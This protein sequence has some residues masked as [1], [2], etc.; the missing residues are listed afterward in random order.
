V[1]DS[2]VDLKKSAWALKAAKI[3]EIWWVFAAFGAHAMHTFRFTNESSK[4]LPGHN[5][6]IRLSLNF[7]K[8]NGKWS[9]LH[10]HPIDARR[11]TA[12]RT[13]RP[14]L[15][16]R[17]GCEEDPV[18]DRPYYYYTYIAYYVLLLLKA[19]AATASG[20]QWCHRVDWRR[21]GNTRYM[22]ADTAR[23]WIP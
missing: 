16:D 4:I 13:H 11:L 3:H 23:G 1:N 15:S 21:G 2:F 7:W 8:I 5:A 17:D 10:T 22:D 6:E 9:H 19:A 14:N 18:S 12:E 20:C